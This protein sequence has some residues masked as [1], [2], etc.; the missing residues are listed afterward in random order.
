MSTVVG[1][2]IFGTIS[3]GSGMSN[4][5]HLIY[6]ENAARWIVFNTDNTTT[7]KIQAYISSSNDLS[8]AT[9]SALTSSPVFTNARAHGNDGRN[10][11]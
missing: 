7:T 5:S 9:W 1:T 8:T 2:T 4:G 6:A 3:N 10:L 11:D